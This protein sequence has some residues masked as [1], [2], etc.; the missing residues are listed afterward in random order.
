MRYRAEKSSS[1]SS[2]A[3]QHLGT[4]EQA[5]Q[6]S[7]VLLTLTARVYHSTYLHTDT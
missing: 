7:H 3:L 1:I 5:Q 2:G 4:K 6:G